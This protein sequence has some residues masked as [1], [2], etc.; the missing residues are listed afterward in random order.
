MKNKI[1]IINLFRKVICSLTCIEQK[2]VNIKIKQEAMVFINEYIMQYENYLNEKTFLDYDIVKL[3]DF[4]NNCYE[5]VKIFDFAEDVEY[6][7]KELLVE[8]KKEVK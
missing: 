1:E 2:T 5:D 3:I 7:A 6:G 8:I 4:C